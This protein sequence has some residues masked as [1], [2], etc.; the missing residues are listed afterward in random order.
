MFDTFQRQAQLLMQENQV[1]LAEDKKEVAALKLADKLNFNWK[2]FAKTE[3]FRELTD[4]RI[5]FQRDQAQFNNENR[6][7]ARA[8]SRWLDRLA[9]ADN[10]EQYGDFKHALKDLELIGKETD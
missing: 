4:A 6:R 3:I 9:S 5:S 7:Y 1:T 8:Y 2:F 10:H